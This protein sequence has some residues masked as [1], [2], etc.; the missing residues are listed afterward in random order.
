M[1]QEDTLK[2]LEE[3][4]KES[5]IELCKVV[6]SMDEEEFEIFLKVLTRDPTKPLDLEDIFK[7]TEHESE[8]EIEVQGLA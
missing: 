7:E 8:E 3:E 4:K 6:R 5:L 2:K 1:N